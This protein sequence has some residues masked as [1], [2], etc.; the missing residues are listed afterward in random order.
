MTPEKL[1]EILL[2]EDS[3]KDVELIMA[4]LQ[5]HQL[6]N[7]VIVVRDGAAALDYLFRE[8]DFAQRDACNPA[9]VLLDLKMPKIDGLEVLSRIRS[10]P[11]LK[12]TPVVVL[13]SSQEERD[14]VESYRLG[15]NAYVVKPIRFS[16]FVEAVSQLGLFWALLNVPPPDAAGS[17]GKG[18]DDEIANSQPGG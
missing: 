14:V 4:A 17:R 12:F 7:R 2:A 16:D 3:A 13:T 9:V 8:G 11:M 15:V 5:K 10:N 18:I 6:A 1:K